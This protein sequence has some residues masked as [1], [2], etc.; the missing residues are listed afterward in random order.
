VTR[1]RVLGGAA[2]AAA[3]RLAAVAVGAACDARGAPNGHA[4][5]PNMLVIVTCRQGHDTTPSRCRWRSSIFGGRCVHPY[6]ESVQVPFHARWRGPLP[7]DG[8]S[9]RMVANN[10][11]RPTVLAAAG[12]ESAVPPVPPL[13]A[14]PAAAFQCVGRACP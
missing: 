8:S 14:R 11:I 6:S 12:V 2:L 3:L 1:N 9:C 5:D 10:N 7:A 4:N 13:G